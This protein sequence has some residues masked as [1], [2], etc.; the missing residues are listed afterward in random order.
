MRPHIRTFAALLAITMIASALAG[1]VGVAYGVHQS[2][3]PDLDSILHAELSLTAEQDRTLAQMERSF[4]TKRER[5]DA[6]MRAA[7]RELAAAVTKQHA[8][9]PA[10][11]GAIERFHRAMMALQEE[12][13]RHVLGMR[14]MLTPEQARRFD[15]IIAEN[16]SDRSS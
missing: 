1:W 9:G 11:Q 15:V 8:Y 4:T 6:E 12:T 7:N 3:H 2:K 14:E 10:A 13:V 5:Y 16:L